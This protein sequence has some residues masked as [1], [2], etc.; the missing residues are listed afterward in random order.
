M[1]L[2]VPQLAALRAH[3]RRQRA[4]LIQRLRINRFRRQLHRRTAKIFPVG[5]AGM[6]AHR[7]AI[8]QRFADALQHH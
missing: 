7:D 8:F 5:K 6:R 4:N 3:Q 2:D 1:R